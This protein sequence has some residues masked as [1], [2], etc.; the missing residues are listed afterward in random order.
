MIDFSRAYAR[1]SSSGCL[2]RRRRAEDAA[3]LSGKTIGV[4][5]GAVEDMVLTALAPKDGRCKNAMRT[6]RCRR[7]FPD[8]QYVA[9]GNL[10]VAVSHARTR[11]SPGAELYAERFSVLYRSE[12]K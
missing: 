6:P 11:E 8:R 7:I 3:A 4:T 12:E 10:V 2:A 5:R 1:R 9:T